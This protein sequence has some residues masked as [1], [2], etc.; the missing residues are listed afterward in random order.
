MKVCTARWPA[1]ALVVGMLGSSPVAGAPAGPATHVLI[2]QTSE[3]LGWA[4][5]YVAQAEKLFDKNGVDAEIQIVKGDAA[6]IPAV[7]AGNAQF[8]ASTTIASL[9]AISKGEHFLIIAPYTD[10]FV[11]Q[12][13]IRKETAARLGTG[14][15]TSLGEKIRKLKGLT[16][17]VLDV[18]GALHLLLNGL[19]RQ[20]GLDPNRDFTVTAISPYPTLLAALQ[21]G[22][23]DAA[24]TAIPFGYVAVK[25]GYAVMLAD[26]WAG[27][28]PAFAGAVHESLFTTEAYGRAHPQTVEAVRRAIGEA[29]AFIHDSP[30]RAI[31]DLTQRFP[32]VGEETVRRI[33]V[34]GAAGFPRTATISRKGFQIVRDFT[35]QTVSP[36]VA[37]IQYDQVIWMSA[38]EKP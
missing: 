14:P 11:V 30:D 13:V 25:G 3:A 17:G 23:I 33:I 36:E 26:F 1:L 38:Q 21:R 27:E 9:Q 12:A 4:A 10:Q 29:L 20:Y 8:G 18:G 37:K 15:S 35:A 7:A 22:Q 32:N 24:F 19:A 16:I 28:V 31:A 34:T 6:T 5:D 2:A